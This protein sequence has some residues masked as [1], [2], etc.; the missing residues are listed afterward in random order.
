M[1]QNSSCGRGLDAVV[2]IVDGRLFDRRSALIIVNGKI[3]RPAL[4]FA[5]ETH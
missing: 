5:S 3:M 2:V 4:L 1:K